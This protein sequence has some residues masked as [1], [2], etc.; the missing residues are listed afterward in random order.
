MC[1]FI[2][3]VHFANLSTSLSL[4]TR[5]WVPP[6]LYPIY[7]LLIF[8]SLFLITSLWVLSFIYPILSVNLYCFV[9]ACQGVSKCPFHLSCYPLPTSCFVFSCQLVSAAPWAF[10]ILFIACWSLLLYLYS[11]ACEYCLCSTCLLTAEYLLAC[12]CYFSF[13]LFT[14]C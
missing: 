11:P 3:P 8:F 10:F 9:S 2:Y 1:Y 12:E 14:A 13:V 6:F 4:L 7:C 5:M